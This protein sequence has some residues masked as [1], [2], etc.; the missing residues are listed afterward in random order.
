MANQIPHDQRILVKGFL[1]FAFGVFHG[2]RI[3]P[4]SAQFVNLK[5]FGATPTTE[6]A[7]FAIPTLES[8]VDGAAFELD[9]LFRL[10]ADP[11]FEVA[12]DRVLVAFFFQGF[13][14]G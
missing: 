3:M 2:K 1:R 14:R 11:A 13:G 7:P 10:E 5:W 6:A 9:N 4:D 12:I 8:L